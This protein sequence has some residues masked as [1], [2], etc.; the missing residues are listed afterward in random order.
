MPVAMV[1]L[2]SYS[3]ATLLGAWLDWWRAVVAGVRELPHAAGHS[4]AAA[5]AYPKAARGRAARP[6]GRGLLAR[7]QG[8]A[9]ARRPD[10]VGGKPRHRPS[11]VAS[12]KIDS[13]SGG[14]TARDEPLPYFRC[15][16]I[17]GSP[18]TGRQGTSPCPTSRRPGDWLNVLSY[19]VGD[20]GLARRVRGAIRRGAGN[21]LLVDRDGRRGHEAGRGRGY[22]R[23]IGRGHSLTRRSVGGRWLVVR[24]LRRAEGRG[25]ARR[26]GSVRRWRHR[27]ATDGRAAGAVLLRVAERRGDRRGGGRGRRLRHVRR[28]TL[29]AEHVD[30]AEDERVAD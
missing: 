28:A 13:G 29:A 2:R 30:G 12:K 23:L 25:A 1:W 26:G 22:A 5:R 18:S 11:R 16:K 15:G 20:P 17:D 27:A 3:M 7:C 14:R 10:G 6:D 4:R 24:S 19:A 21:R 8:T 9:V